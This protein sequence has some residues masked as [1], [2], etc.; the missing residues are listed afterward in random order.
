[1]KKMNTM[2]LRAIQQKDIDT[3]IAELVA[4]EK[5]LQRLPP[6]TDLQKAKMEQSMAIDHLYYSSK[7]EGT[8]LTKARIDKAIHGHQ[9]VPQA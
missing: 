9:E 3:R 7:I 6:L 5:N 1:M 4:L 8:N 2:N